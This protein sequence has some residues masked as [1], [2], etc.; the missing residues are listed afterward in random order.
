MWCKS[1][2]VCF[3]YVVEKGMEQK[4]IRKTDRLFTCDGCP[5]YKDGNRSTM[6]CS[7]LECWQESEMER[8]KNPDVRRYEMKMNTEKVTRI[9][10]IEDAKRKYVKW[11]CEPIFQ[12]Q[13][14]GRTLKIFIDK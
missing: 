3:Y 4:G 5:I 2:L 9:E 14:G 12:L 8:I 10:V 6:M 1:W 7:H 11:D 13:D